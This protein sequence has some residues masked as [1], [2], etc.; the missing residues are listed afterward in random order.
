MAALTRSGA[1]KASEIVMLTLRTLHRSRLAMLSA[2]AF[3]PARSSASQR[4]PAQSMRPGAR[5]TRSVS[6]ERVAAASP[7]AALSR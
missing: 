4:R 6:D 3:A 2:F 1:R 5:G 7:L